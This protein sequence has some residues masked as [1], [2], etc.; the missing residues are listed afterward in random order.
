MKLL[1]E[2]LT[3]PDDVSDSTDCGTVV[4]TP[5]LSRL[6]SEVAVAVDGQGSHDR[7]ISDH[8]QK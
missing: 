2:I 1:L 5:P 8:R 4:N 6:I 3:K 7:F